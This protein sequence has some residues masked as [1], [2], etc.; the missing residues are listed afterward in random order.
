M[1]TNEENYATRNAMGTGPFMLKERK[2]GERT[3]LVPN[4]G[5]WGKPAHNLTEVIFTPVANPA[6]RVA[7]LKASDIDMTYAVPPP[8]TEPLKRDATIKG[9]A[10]PG[11]RLAYLG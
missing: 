7:A 6:T 10:R 11:T 3:V 9:L 5:W 1:T 2:A 4:P 8:D